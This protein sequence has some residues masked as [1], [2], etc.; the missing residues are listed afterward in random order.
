MNILACIWF[1]K[2]LY[3]LTLDQR[4]GFINV[5]LCTYLTYSNVLD[6]LMYMSKVILVR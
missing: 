1:G 5:Y 4:M 6:I 3:C 2:R